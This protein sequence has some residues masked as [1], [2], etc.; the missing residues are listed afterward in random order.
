MDVLYPCCC[1]LDVHAKTVVAC[2]IKNGKRIKRTYST[3]TQDLLALGDW[4]LENGVTHLA[5]ESTGVYW[6]PVYTILEPVCEILLVNAH[7]VKQ[8]PGRKTDQTDAEWLA[9]LLRHGLLKASFI[10]TAPIRDLR[11]LTRH[12]SM[13]V[14]DRTQLA[15]RIQKV[16]ESGNIKLGQVLSDAL[17]VSGRKMLRALADGERDVDRIVALGSPQ[18]RDKREELRKAV[19]GRLT[20]AQRFVLGEL[21]DRYGEVEGAIGRAEREIEREIGGS[22]QDPFVAEAVERLDAITGIGKTVA[23][24]I[25]SEIG[26]DMQRFATSAHLA[27][28]A[29]LCPGNNQSGGKRRS[30]KTTKGNAALRAALMQAAVVA[31]RKKGSYFAM[32]YGRWKGR[33]GHKRALVAVAHK[34]LVVIYK[35][36]KDREEYREEVL[37]ERSRQDIEHECAR[38]VRRLERLGHRVAIESVTSGQDAA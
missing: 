9:D 7:H 8:V 2:I 11:E 31:T 13:L 34:L 17:G 19:E 20:A 28:W 30:G 37:K 27:S 23:Q 35:L 26:I 15:N 29:G 5:M 38:L 6:K 22:E 14:R 25:V 4:L 10:P 21:L 36:L 16:A 24:V 1:G 3:M 33:L 32:I 18:L 12:R